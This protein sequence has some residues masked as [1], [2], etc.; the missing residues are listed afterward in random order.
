MVQ[1][2]EVQ[3]SVSYMHTQNG[4][5]ESLIKRIKL[6]AR[7]LLH[8]CNLSITY[9]GHTILHVVDL[10]QLRP[11]LYHITSLLHLAHGNAPSISHLWKFGCVS[12]I[13]TD[14]TTTS[15]R[16]GPS[17]ENGYLCGISFH[18]HYKIPGAYD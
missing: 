2:I 9:W 3:H 14:F 17:Q 10:I 18:I 5:V 6:T 15:Y 11:T 8:N 1:G 16:D 12:C 13:C 7:P 4:L